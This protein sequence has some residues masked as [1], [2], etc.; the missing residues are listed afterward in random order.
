VEEMVVDFFMYRFPLFTIVLG[1]ERGTFVGGNN[2]LKKYYVGMKE[3]IRRLEKKNP[4]SDLLQGFD[5]FDNKIWE[6]FYDSQDIKSRKNTKSFKA[7][8]P[9]RF[10]E[11]MGSFKHERKRMNKNKEL[12]EFVVVKN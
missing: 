7:N 9:K 5:Q 4:K 6:A 1:S 12:N 8:I 3:I 11:G 10:L 2:Q